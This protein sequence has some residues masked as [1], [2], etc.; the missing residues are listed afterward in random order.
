MP[1]NIHPMVDNGVPK[2]ADDFSGG[3][4]VCHCTDKPVTVEIG[5]NV[6]H[7]HACAARRRAPPEGIGGRRTG[8]LQALPARPSAPAVGEFLVRHAGD[9]QLDL[10]DR[11][12]LRVDVVGDDGAAAQHDDPVHHLEDV[13]DVVGDEDAGVAAVAGVAHEVEHAAGLG[14]AEIVGRLVEDDQVAVEIHR[15]GDRHRLPLAARERARSASSVGMFL[16]M[17]TRRR[18]SPATRFIVAWSM[19]LRNRG[20]GRPARGRGRGCGRSR[21]G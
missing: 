7:N 13:V 6:L 20:P 19:R 1:V 8:A 3:T 17:P 12:L 9:D 2:G 18:S 16:V 5:S 21:A 10:V 15:A 4:L 11:G 14:D